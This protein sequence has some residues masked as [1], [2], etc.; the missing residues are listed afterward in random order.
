MTKTIENYKQ[1]LTNDTKTEVKYTPYEYGKEDPGKEY[2]K[3][4]VN[5]LILDFFEIKL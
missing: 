5:N 2:S 4:D 3:I 1:N